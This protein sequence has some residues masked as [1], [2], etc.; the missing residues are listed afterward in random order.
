M[1]NA[2]LVIGDVVASAVALRVAGLF[3]TPATGLGTIHN[4]TTVA[5]FVCFLGVCTYLLGGYRVLDFRSAERDLEI[6][7][8]AAVLGILM[9]LPS[10]ILSPAT[11]PSLRW[12]LAWSAGLVVLVPAVRLMLHAS[13]DGI[14]HLARRDDRVLLIGRAAAIAQA[15]G[16]L[17]TV[18]ESG[19]VDF[20]IPEA[21]VESRLSGSSY[22]D[23][24]S[25]VAVHPGARR[26]VAPILGAVDA[27]LDE[28][29][30]NSVRCACVAPQGLEHDDVAMLVDYFL[31]RRLPVCMTSDELRTPHGIDSSRH[32]GLRIVDGGARGAVAQAISETA[33]RAVD[34]V[35][36]LLALPF[37]GVAYVVLGIAMR[38]EDRGPVIYRR[39]VVGQSGAEFDAYKFRSMRADADEILEDDPVLKAAYE[40]NYKLEDDPRRTRV[41]DFIR[42]SSIDEIPQFINVLRGQMSIVGP[43]MKVKDEIRR[44]YSGLE[45]E[46]FSVKPGITGFWQTNGRQETTYD[47]RV[48]MDLYYIAHWSVWLDTM[49]LIKTV[50]KV[51]KRQGAL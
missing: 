17:A 42:R 24:V 51:I 1:R 9:G 27:W 47:E 33:K 31:C 26:T 22:P 14:G 23:D 45:D 12:L 8:K 44:Y 25:G 49:I 28:N 3:V 16:R 4:V 6:A 7:T 18:S 41:G 40:Q 13:M 11:G 36:S 43:R 35:G 21:W 2:G 20:V 48:R 15:K 37:I 19:H 10:I 32:A 50:W 38:L 29:G 5:T 34:I 30:E 46:L 39:R